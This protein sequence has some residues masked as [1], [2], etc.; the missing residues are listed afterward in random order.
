MVEGDHKDGID[1]KCNPLTHNKWYKLLM[2]DCEAGLKY[3]SIRLFGYDYGGLR[4]SKIGFLV[5]GHHVGI[6]CTVLHL[7]T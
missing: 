6:N 3:F 1:N 5:Y 4:E 2:K 7:L